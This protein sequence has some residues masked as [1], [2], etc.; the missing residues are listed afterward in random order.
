MRWLASLILYI[1]LLG[2]ASLQTEHDRMVAAMERRVSFK[3]SREMGKPKYVK[4]CRTAPEG[5]HTRL[6]AFASMFIRSGRDHSVDPWVLAAMA[7]RES[8]FNPWAEGSIGERGV[9]QLARMWTRDLPQLR[10]PRVMARCR[11]EVGACQSQVID[12]AA[13]MLA[14]SIE[15]CGSLLGGLTRYNTGRCLDEPNRYARQV[16]RIRGSLKEEGMR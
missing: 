10:D 6:R 12:F 2:E 7:A 3:M 16:L 1:P 11:R 9:L 5:C 14:R 8:G 15:K 4:H 13:G